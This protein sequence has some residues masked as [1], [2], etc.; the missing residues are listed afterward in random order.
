MSNKIEPRCAYC[1]WAAPLEEGKLICEK[2]GV[3]P[4][5]GRCRRFRYDP[6]RRVPP[7]P[8]PPDFSRFSGEDFT[9]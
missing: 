3:V 7:R 8:E 5:E 6:L 4:E 2:K 9:L 1:A